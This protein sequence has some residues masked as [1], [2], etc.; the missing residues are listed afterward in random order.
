MP[1]QYTEIFAPSKMMKMM[2]ILRK[3]LIILIFLLKTLTEAVLMSTHNL[4]FGAKIIKNML[5]LRTPVFLYMS[6][7]WTCLRDEMDVLCM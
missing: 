7:A 3:C 1:K 2:K 5:T 6:I 4:C